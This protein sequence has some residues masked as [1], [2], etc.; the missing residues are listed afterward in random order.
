MPLQFMKYLKLAVLCFLSQQVLAQ[1]DETNLIY[2]FFG[3]GELND[4][5]TIRNFGMG[6]AGFASS[7]LLY[8]NIQNPAAIDHFQFTIFNIEYGLNRHFLESKRGRQ[9]VLDGNISHLTL[10]VPLF[11]KWKSGL[12]I[13]PYSQVRYNVNFI[14]HLTGTGQFVRYS[15]TGTGGISNLFWLHSFKIKDNFSLGLDLNFYFGNVERSESSQ[16]INFQV[17]DKINSSREQRYRGFSAFPS[18]LWKIALEDKLSFN[19]GGTYQYKFKLNLQENIAK[20]FISRT[21]VFTDSEIIKTNNLQ[22]AV[23]ALYKIGFSLEK[24]DKLVVAADLVYQNWKDFNFEINNQSFKTRLAASFGLEY[25]PDILSATN[26]LKRIAYRFGFRYS[27]LP[28]FVNKQNIEELNASVGFSLPVGKFSKLNLAFVAG[29]RGNQENEL[30]ADRFLQFH[31][32]MTIN[33]QWFIKK[34]FD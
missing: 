24:L 23:P 11:Q 33:S 22:I 3:L 14:E 17:G 26:Y 10:I 4:N 27:L 1:V 31:F 2:S 12:G 21:G 13:R 15:Y 29:Q 32:G 7:S 28:Y 16:L 8:S 25:Y 6:Q 20:Q 30:I 18:F 5:V 19:I 9:R 34:R